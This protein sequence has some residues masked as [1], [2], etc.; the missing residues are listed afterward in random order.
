MTW[1][2]RTEDISGVKHHQ[3][4]DPIS[5]WLGWRQSDWVAQRSPVLRVARA[6]VSV[7]CAPKKSR[8]WPHH[9]RSSAHFYVLQC[10]GYHLNL[11]FLIIVLLWLNI[12]TSL[13]Y[14]PPAEIKSIKWSLCACNPFTSSVS[15]SSLKGFCCSP[16]LWKRIH[17]SDCL[18]VR[19]LAMHENLS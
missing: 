11:F 8:W 3:C 4:S 16:L 13:T 6:G 7:G 5:N 10:P 19:S 2:W 9:D 18:K 12:G 17:W 1:R 15:V 14:V